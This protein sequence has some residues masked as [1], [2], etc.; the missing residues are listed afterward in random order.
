[1][2][3]R[4]F[5]DGFKAEALENLDLLNRD[6]LKLEKEPNP[7]WIH[8]LFRV[9]HTLK[10]SAGMMGFLKIQKIAHCLED[11][12]QSVKEK[13]ITFNST[14]ADTVFSALDLIKTAVEN[15]GAGKEENIDIDEVL[16]KLNQF[17]QGPPAID[18]HEQKTEEI[19]PPSSDEKPAE[20]KSRETPPPPAKPDASERQ[21][22]RE[23]PSDEFIRVPISR[24][25]QLLNLI[26]EIVI[27]KV[28]SS[29]K[30]S[31]LKQLSKQ[32]VRTERLLA[33]W[34]SFFKECFSSNGASPAKA[35]HNANTFD[36]KLP[37][38]LNQLHDF[39]S[40]FATFKEKLNALSEEIQIETFHLNPIVEELQQ[41]I[42]EIRMLPCSTIFEGFPRLVRDIAK[43]QGKEVEFVVEG[44]DTELDKKVLEAIKAPLIH[45]LRNAIDHG[46]ESIQD[47]QQAH[48]AP[49]GRIVLSA[50]QEGGKVI[51]EVQDNGQGID[52]DVIKSTALKK[53][54]VTEEEIREM[55]EDAILNLVFADGFSTAPII[56]DISGRGVGLS[57]VRSELERLKGSIIVTSEKGQ[58]TTM[59][60]ELPLTIA[61]LQVLVVEVGGMTWGFPMNNL[62]ESLKVPRN[63]IST[64]E[65]RMIIQIRDRSIPVVKL[66][67]LLGIPDH[68]PSEKEGSASRSLQKKTSQKTESEEM[69]VIIVNT[70]NKRIAFSVD[71]ILGE[72]EVFIKNLGTHIGKVQGIGGATILASGEIMLIL[73]VQDLL[74][75]SHHAHPSDQHRKSPDTSDKKH[76]KILIVDDSLTIRELM[77]SILK[78]NGY[79]VDT[80]MDGLDALDR[81]SKNSFNLIVSDI[82]M[83]RMDGFE[84][85]RNIRL[86]E[87]SKSIP[88]IFITSLAKEDEKRKGI[89][90]GADAYIVKNQFEQKSL[91]EM[92]ERFS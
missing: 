18:S 76:K 43:Q 63:T 49:A 40:S 9:A 7:E 37:L 59:R 33:E 21:S 16:R 48:K 30:L 50:F 67:S 79:E 27:N 4:R 83:P 12:F 44:E 31:T 66:S 11:L 5:L 2:D 39:Q 74:S 29:Y 75:M 86:N 62:E 65:N 22:E 88:L 92:I 1:M 56:T 57:V 46:I 61:I 78:N 52:L 90:V 70:R 72:R 41:K 8:E 58:G 20:I 54:I 13:K 91:I 73:D 71:R 85:C 53:H 69:T 84:L 15:V 87:K 89:E 34:S 64:I 47:R 17:L 26:G 42:K 38:L 28:K 14:A 68:R 23:S 32:S 25:N 55:K 45:I 81:I 10:G 82:Q 60:L 19:K 51:I 24:I 36:E 6:I 80:A 77:K 35:E 3:K